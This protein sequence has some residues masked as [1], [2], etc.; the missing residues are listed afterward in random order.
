VQIETDAIK[1]GVK[2]ILGPD[3]CFTHF[4]SIVERLLAR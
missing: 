3:T 4:N 2:K 1:D